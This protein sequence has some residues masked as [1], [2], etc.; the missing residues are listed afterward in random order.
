MRKNW[1]LIGSSKTRAMNAALIVNPEL[2]S[3]FEEVKNKEKTAR[4]VK[5]L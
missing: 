3:L 4:S 2:R 1:L 5:S